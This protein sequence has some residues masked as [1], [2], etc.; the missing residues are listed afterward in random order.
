[1]RMAAE[2]AMVGEGEGYDAAGRVGTELKTRSFY[3]SLS[4][5]VRLVC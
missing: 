2:A 5:L 4:V 1:V 3:L